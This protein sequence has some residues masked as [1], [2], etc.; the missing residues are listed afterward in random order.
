[1]SDAI[2]KA[3]EAGHIPMTSDGRSLMAIMLGRLGAAKGGQARQASMSKE[4]RTALAKK[5]SAAR[6]GSTSIL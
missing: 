6:W 4:E 1:M 3:I 2:A 5:A